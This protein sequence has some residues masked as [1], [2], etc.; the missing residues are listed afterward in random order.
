[1]HDTTDQHPT[2]RSSHR[3]LFAEPAQFGELVAAMVAEQAPHTFAVVLVSGEND[4][5]EVVAWGLALDD[6]A[7]MIMTDGRNQFSLARPENA[8]KYFSGRPDV[9]PRLVWANRAAATIGTGFG[10]DQP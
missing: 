7:Y 4:D 10:Q 8:L 2:C 1:V 5:A 6:C 9:Q 3:E